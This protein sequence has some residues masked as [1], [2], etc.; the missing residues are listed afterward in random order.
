MQKVSR[1]MISV[2]F[3]MEN[4][5]APFSARYLNSVNEEY[6]ASAPITVYILLLENGNMKL[7][8]PFTIPIDNQQASA[9]TKRYNK[10]F[11]R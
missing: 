10:S 8:S 7:I 9:V 5:M 1:G 2:Q 3:S 6:N 4:P 11:N